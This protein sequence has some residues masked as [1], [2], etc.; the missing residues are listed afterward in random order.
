VVLGSCGG[1]QNVAKVL[2]AAPDAHIISSKQTGVGAI[3]EPIV[4]AINTS[5]LEQSD[6]N[7]INIWKGLEE[8]FVKKPELYPRYRD[9]VPPHK[10]LGVLFI[11]AYHQMLNRP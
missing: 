4:R 6:V 11:K 1:Y 8:Y 2:Q 10:N 9:Y 3:N 7:W 5:L